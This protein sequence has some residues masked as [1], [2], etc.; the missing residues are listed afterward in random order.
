MSIKHVYTRLYSIFY[1]GHLH[2]LKAFHNATYRTAK[3]IEKN[4]LKMELAVFDLLALVTA[5]KRC[6]MSLE[7]NLA[8][9]H[10]TLCLG[11]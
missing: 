10:F 1:G 11:A 5:V 6:V 4:Q 2:C 8:S 7:S 9:T 3:V